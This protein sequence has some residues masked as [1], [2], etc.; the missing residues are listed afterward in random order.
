[1]A[2]PLFVFSRY[3]WPYP[4]RPV[5][6]GLLTAALVAQIILT[7]KVPRLRWVLP[8]VGL[9]ILAGSIPAGFLIPPQRGVL[10]GEIDTIFTAVLPGAALLLGSGLGWFS[11]W[12][13]Q[14]LK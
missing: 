4:P 3:V 7:H 13:Y 1:M 11:Y 2:H 6:F 12:F 5:F 10:L 14:Y 8:A 9:L